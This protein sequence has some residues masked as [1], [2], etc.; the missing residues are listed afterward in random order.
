MPDEPF[1]TELSEEQRA[2][3][4]REKSSWAQ[5]SQAEKV[6]CKYWAGQAVWQ[7]GRGRHR[8]VG[9]EVG[10][11]FSSPFIHRTPMSGASDP[12]DMRRITWT[13][14]TPRAGVCGQ[15]GMCPRGRRPKRQGGSPGGLSGED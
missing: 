10:V 12:G 1:C 9:W 13:D 11:E 4:E 3:K 7:D 14:R 8:G 6:A 5:L 2:L 15:G